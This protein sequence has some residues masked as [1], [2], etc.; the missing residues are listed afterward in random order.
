M[1]RIRYNGK[2]SELPSLELLQ[3]LLDG[4]KEPELVDVWVA[5][6]NAWLPAKDVMAG[7]GVAKDL[8][9]ENVVLSIPVWS[10]LPAGNWET[11]G[12]VVGASTEGF[13]M[14]K[15]M[16]GFFH[17]VVG[18]ES[19]GHV[20]GTESAAIRA[21]SRASEKAVALG[22]DALVGVGIEATEFATSRSSS[23]LLCVATG[24][25]VRR[26]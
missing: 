21:I 20:A 23:T 24:T 12:V 22:A 26:K 19:A 14:F 4:H 6:Q 16:Q 10:T 25:A 7:T 5:K 3:N 1:I 2:E 8:E 13:N 18:G 17:D 11:L 9:I 15:D